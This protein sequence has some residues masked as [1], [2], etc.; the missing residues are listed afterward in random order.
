VTGERR[1]NTIGVQPHGTTVVVTL[2][3]PDRLNAINEELARELPEALARLASSDTCRAVVITGRGRSFCAGADISE[4]QAME[5]VA[6]ALAELG[7]IRPVFDAV[8]D[9]PLPTVA[10]VNGLALGGGLELALACDFRI[11]GERARVGLPEV[12]LGAL[13][14]GG[15][16]S[17]LPALVG[18][19]R[20]KEIVLTAQPIDARAALRFGLANQ[21]V[22]DAEVLERS[23]AFADMFASKPAALLRLAKRAVQVGA[24]TSAGAAAELELLAT[25]AAFGTHDRAEGMRAFLE[26][27]DASFTGR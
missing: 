21:V 15:G 24:S 9:F 26:K 11:L 13:P 22:T 5:G 1:Y 19:A 18:L 8:A 4:A 23:I 2:D 12:N 7:R 10:A 16:M 14:A 20:T 27:R 25:V 17:R 3:R 6:G